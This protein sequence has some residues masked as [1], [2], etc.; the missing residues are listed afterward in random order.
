[1]DR[2]GTIKV[3]SGRAW[4]GSSAHGQVQ[5][6]PFINPCLKGLSKRARAWPCRAAHFAILVHTLEGDVQGG[7][8]IYLP[9]VK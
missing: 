5:Y 2:P 9:E 6:G 8:P 4:A 1:M 7:N 3:L